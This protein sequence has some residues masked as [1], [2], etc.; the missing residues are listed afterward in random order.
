VIGLKWLCKTKYAVDGSIEY[1]K[2][3]LVEKGFSQQP[4]I[5]YDETCAYVVILNTIRT[6]LP[7]EAQ[8]NGWFINLM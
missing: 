8:C 3:R 1:P 6:Y 5:D 4:C 7:L 2:A